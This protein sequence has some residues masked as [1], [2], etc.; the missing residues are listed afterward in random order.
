MIFKITILFISFFAHSSMAVSAEWKALQ[1]D[2][3]GGIYL[4]LESIKPLGNNQ[5]Q[6][7]ILFSPTYHGIYPGHPFS[8]LFVKVFKCDEKQD[9]TIRSVGF[10]DPMAKGKIVSDVESPETIFNKSIGFDLV[11]MKYICKRQ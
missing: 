4:D 2:K 5:F 7:S 9:R 11:T 1:K 3:T 8:D 6:A 10:F